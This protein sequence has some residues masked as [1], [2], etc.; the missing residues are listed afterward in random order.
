MA[1][2]HF[3]ISNY[4]NPKGKIHLWH[5][6]RFLCHK[7]SILYRSFF[8]YWGRWE[9][10]GAWFPSFWP[11]YH[12]FFLFSGPVG[13]F[14]CLISFIPAP[15]SNFFP[16]F[17]AGRG[18]PVP[19]FLHSGPDFMLFS[20]YRGQWE[21]SGAWFPSF[22]PR[23]HAFFLFSGPVGAF[24]SLVPFI[25][26]PISCFF[27]FF[28]AGGSFPEPGFLNSGP[29]NKLFSFFRGRWGPS[30]A[31]F[32]SFWP[33]YHAFFLF[34]GPVGAFRSLVSFILA[35]ISYFFP[36]FGAGGGL[37]EPGFLHS[38]PDNKLFSSYRGQSPNDKVIKVL[39]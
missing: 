6:L 10:S 18:L 27:P 17:G 25:P 19:G 21:P 33:R 8:S 34:S 29:D 22:W 32:P 36:F 1:L 23:Y 7:R 26:A 2:H 37:P 20:S 30:G 31:W 11:R 12:A 14:R 39:R 3:L 16:F 5:E 35:P 38:G 9:P 4:H 13:A 24:W 28:G 15:I